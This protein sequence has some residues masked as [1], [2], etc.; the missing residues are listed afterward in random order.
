MQSWEQLSE[1]EKDNIYENGSILLDFNLSTKLKYKSSVS[2]CLTL[3]SK[4]SL[5]PIPFR[6]R[7][8]YMYSEICNS[9]VIFTLKMVFRKNKKNEIFHQ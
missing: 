5:L 8:A 3:S 7:Q 4:Y 9:K 1:E 6:L 2:F